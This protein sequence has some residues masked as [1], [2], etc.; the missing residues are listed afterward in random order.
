L[1][2]FSDPL[3]DFLDD[4]FEDVIAEE[5]ISILREYS[6]GNFDDHLKRVI[7][8]SIIE[9]I[10]AETVSNSYSSLEVKLYQPSSSIFLFY[11]LIS[12]FSQ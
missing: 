11:H 8:D 1:I 5:A 6:Q 10:L 4:L 2:D 9:E 12:L 7:Y 3:E